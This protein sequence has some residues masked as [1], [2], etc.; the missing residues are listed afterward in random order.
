MVAGHSL[1]DRN[2]RKA[3][4]GKILNASGNTCRRI[5]LLGID[6]VGVAVVLVVQLAMNERSQQQC[7]G[8]TETDIGVNFVPCNR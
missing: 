4:L 8:T 7:I 6:F 3:S 1:I 2:G 5:S